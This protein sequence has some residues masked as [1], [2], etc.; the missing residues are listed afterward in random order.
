MGRLLNLLN[1]YLLSTYYVP[2]AVLGI[3]DTSVSMAKTPKLM[4]LAV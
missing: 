4:E 3:G 1:Q 2:G